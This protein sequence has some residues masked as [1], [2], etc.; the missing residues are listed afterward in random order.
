MPEISR[1]SK[2]AHWHRAD[3]SK[4]CTTCAETKPLDDF[5][6]YPYTTG[7][8]KRSSRYE[9]RCKDCSKLRRRAQRLAQPEKEAEYSRA[10]VQ[11]DPDVFKRQGER[12]RAT[13]HGRRVKAKAQRLRKA[14]MRSGEENRDPRIAALYQEAMDWEKKL[15]ACVVS[16]E[17]LQLKMHVDHVRPLAKG[18]RH[19]FENLQ[20]LDALENMRKGMS[21]PK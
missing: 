9:S 3:R 14:R 18:G 1:S 12:Y 17:P 7:Q 4:R 5:Y 16:D 13:E 15:Q 10:R 20:I 19:V 6:A 21:C 8:G 11:R 2:N